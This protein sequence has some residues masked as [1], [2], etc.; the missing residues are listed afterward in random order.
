LAKSESL[1]RVELEVL[2]LVAE[3]HPI[4]VREAADK[5]AGTS[6][7]ART[8]VLTVLERLRKKGYLTRRKTGGMNRYSP[9][10]AMTQLIQSLIGEF[11]HRVLG[12]SVSPFVAYLGQKTEVQPEEL[13]ELRRLVRELELRELVRRDPRRRGDA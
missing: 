9:R 10:V 6:G 4:S 7:Q 8:T 12:G 1:G 2:R 13:D 5:L 3:H 11:V